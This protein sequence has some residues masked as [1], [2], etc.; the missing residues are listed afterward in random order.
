[1]T[2]EEP[3]AKLQKEAENKYFKIVGSQKQNL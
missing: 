3:E 1:M 2:R